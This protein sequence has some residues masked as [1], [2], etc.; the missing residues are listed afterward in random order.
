LALHLKTEITDVKIWDFFFEQE[1]PRKRL[2]FDKVRVLPS[3]EWVK[4]QHGSF[5]EK[6]FAESVEDKWEETEEDLPIS[7]TNKFHNKERHLTISCADS[8]YR[9]SS[10][11]RSAKQH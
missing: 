11:V 2:S 5:Q 8:G 3:G 1:E 4:V 10:A 7:L 9:P 6:D